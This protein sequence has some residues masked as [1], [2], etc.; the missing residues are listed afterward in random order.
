MKAVHSR[1]YYLNNW[2]HFIQR[3]PGDNYFNLEAELEMK[4]EVYKDAG[5][6]EEALK[7]I[8]GI[9]AKKISDK[10]F[11]KVREMMAI[12]KRIEAGKAS[13][14]YT[15]E[16]QEYSARAEFRQRFEFNCLQLSI[17]CEKYSIER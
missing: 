7:V 5:I 17:F 4:M 2:D 1:E 3:V 15:T 6:P 12:I 8:T 11:A 14:G 13:F 9:E 16:Q 10:G